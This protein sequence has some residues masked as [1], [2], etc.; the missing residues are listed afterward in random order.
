MAYTVYCHT[1]KVNG[2][3]Y[4]GI[5]RQRCKTRWQGGNGYSSNP[6][7]SAAIKKIWTVWLTC[8]VLRPT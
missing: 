2:K 1:N 5:T 7:F 3:K 4:F 6:Y 8:L